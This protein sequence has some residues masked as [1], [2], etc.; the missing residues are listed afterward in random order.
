MRILVTGGAGFIGQHLVQRLTEDSSASVIIFDN[1]HRGSAGSLG[2][3]AKEVLFHRNDIRDR[4]ALAESMRGCE[5]VFHL[6]AQSNVMGAVQDVEYSFSTNVQ[7]TFNVL[8]AAQEAGVRRVVF[9]SSREVYGDPETLPVPE[10]AP[11]QPKNAYGVSKASGEMYCRPLRNGGPEIVILRIANAYGLGDKDRV[12]PLFIENATRGLPLVLYG[13]TQTL[14]FVS[15]DIVV[16][17]LLKAG[18]GEYIREPVNIGS[19]KGT[20][21]IDL[22]NRII[23]LTSSRSPLQIETRR[24]AE[25]SAF[26]ANIARAQELFGLTVLEDPLAGLEDMIRA[27]TVT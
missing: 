3:R 25:V 2:T 19:G 20:R 4:A 1:L 9:T 13:G 12:I 23:Q 22:A 10:T 11:M 17:V 16:D 7:G 27:S 6:A 14:D 26:V 8:R 15:V 5:L 24:E 21:I 18:F